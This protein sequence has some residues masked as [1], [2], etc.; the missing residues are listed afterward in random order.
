VTKNSLKV[1]NN[2][3][4][5]R[6]IVQVNHHSKLTHMPTLVRTSQTVHTQ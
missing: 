4:F 2:S 1:T 5:K 3:L 6:L